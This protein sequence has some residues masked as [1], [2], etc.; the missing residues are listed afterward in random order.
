M[1]GG[2]AGK[3]PST[4]YVIA[5]DAIPSDTSSI[6]SFPTSG[7]AASPLQEPILSGVDILGVNLVDKR[8][9]RVVVPC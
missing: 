1:D 5:W 8:I 9:S 3:P 4:L 2:N 7:G 6:G